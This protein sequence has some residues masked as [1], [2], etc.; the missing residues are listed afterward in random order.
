MLQAANYEQ[1]PTFLAEFTMRHPENDNG[2]LMWHG[3]APLSMCAPDEKIRIGH[4]WI[5]PSPQSGMIHQKLKDGP[6]TMLR[7]D[8]DHGQYQLALGEGRSIDGPKT[9]NSYLW[10][11]VNDWPCWERHLMEG[12]FIHHVALGYGHYMP[13]LIE[14]CKYIPGL[15]PLV[16]GSCK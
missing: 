1:D 9:L 8:G 3:S 14:S 6:L 5:L 13:A 7:M 2:V 16:L 11:E 4:H 10:A 12:P 15:D